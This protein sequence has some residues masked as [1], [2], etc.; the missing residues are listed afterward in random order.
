MAAFCGGMVNH[1]SP[2]QHCSCLFIAEHWRKL[3]S[4]RTRVSQWSSNDFWWMS[5][6]YRDILNNTV[7]LLC[8][9]KL[10]GSRVHFVSGSEIPANIAN[11][12]LHGFKTSSRQFQLVA[13]ALVV[14]R[15]LF[16]LREHDEPPN[17]S[18]TWPL[19]W[20]TDQDCGLG[21]SCLL[22]IR[23]AIM[24]II[25][26][27]CELAYGETL[28]SWTSETALLSGTKEN[29]VYQRPV[30]HVP[31]SMCGAVPK[32]ESCRLEDSDFG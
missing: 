10:W 15:L 20:N 16:P 21:N 32:T 17:C 19:L 8:P 7:S 26:P 31:L 27:C 9:S 23:R 29:V 22:R 6:Y 4:L 3:E 14:S 12:G 5:L 11:H 30:T 28:K 25:G 18:W 1:S 24:Q 2:G 13:V